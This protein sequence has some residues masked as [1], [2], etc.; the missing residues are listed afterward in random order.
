MSIK[1]V[2]IRPEDELDDVKIDAIAANYDLPEGEILP[3][4]QKIDLYLLKKVRE[5]EERIRDLE[6]LALSRK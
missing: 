1:N 3:E 6:A 4:A 2:T 5:L